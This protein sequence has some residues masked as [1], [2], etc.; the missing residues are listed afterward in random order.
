MCLSHD[1]LLLA[2]SQG[3]VSLVERT[4]LHSPTQKPRTQTSASMQ[5]PWNL[6]IRCRPAYLPYLF[7]SRLSDCAEGFILHLV[8]PAFQSSRFDARVSARPL[9]ELLLFEITR[10]QVPAFVV[11]IGSS[12]K[13]TMIAMIFFWK[14]GRAQNLRPHN[15]EHPGCLG[16]SRHVLFSCP[17]S[18]R[19]LPRLFPL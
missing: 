3:D 17:L 5:R 16:K 14:I 9:F 7:G 10:S 2:C 12:Q 1:L 8:M 11:E 15:I 13:L 4:G 19:T 18:L 6:V